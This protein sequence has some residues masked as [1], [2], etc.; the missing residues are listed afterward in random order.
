M[1]VGYV[2]VG[3][4]GS[5]SLFVGS[6]QFSVAKTHPNYKRI[7]T[8]IEQDAAE[9]VFLTLLDIPKAVNKFSH[10]KVHV[11]SGVVYYGNEPVHN[12]VADRILRFMNE[13]IPFQ[14]LIKFLEKLMQN[15]SFRSREQ[16]YAF[17]EHKALPITTDG[18]VLAYKAVKSNFLDKYSGKIDNSP[19]QIVSMDRGLVDDNPDAHCSKGLHCGALDYVNWYHSAGDKTVVV[20]FNPSDAVS[21]PGDHSRMKLR[22]CKYEVVR[23][24]VG[25]LSAPLYAS[26]ADEFDADKYEDDDEWNEWEDDE[27]DFD[28]DDDEGDESSSG[29]GTDDNF[30][31]G[32]VT[33]TRSQTVPGPGE[34]VAARY[35][36]VKPNGQ[37]YHNKRDSK[38]HFVKK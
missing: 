26:N 29:C 24:Y 12:V 11:E 20:K 33:S 36:G 16:L 32:Q 27:D 28:E 4:T 21:V 15:P 8:A 7:L 17:L 38:G 9:K 1:S 3:S 14:P 30:E 31:P 18:D 10:G 22:V 23:E 2:M 19:G 13:G 34:V 35:F 37:K 5:I 6:E 25:E